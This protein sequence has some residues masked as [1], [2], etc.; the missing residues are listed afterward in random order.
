MAERHT[1]PGDLFTFEERWIKMQERFNEVLPSMPIY[2]N[3]Y[4]DFHTDWLQNYYPNAEY[5]WPMA[6][7]YAFYA[8]PEPQPE[9]EEILAEGDE[10]AEGEE[11]FFDDGDS[12]GGEVFFDD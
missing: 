12:G 1:E 5:S 4:F 8:E 7:M 11:V 3:I 9:E 6:I 10:F 2:T